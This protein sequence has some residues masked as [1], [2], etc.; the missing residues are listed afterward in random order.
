[1]NPGDR[2]IYKGA[3]HLLYGRKGTVVALVRR[4]DDDPER[5]FDV[6]WR[7]DA[8]IA[9]NVEWLAIP[10]DLRTEQ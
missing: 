8:V 9:G 1:M 5:A 3:A 10:R 4:P 6:W 7:S 2:V